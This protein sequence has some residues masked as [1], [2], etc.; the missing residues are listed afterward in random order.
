M[1]IYNASMKIKQRLFQLS[2]P[3]GKSVFLWG[4]RK[5]GKSYWVR[6]HQPNAI[7]I[8]L[9]KT[10][11]FADYA[12]RPPLL[13]ERYSEATSLVVIDEVQ[14]LPVILNEVHWLISLV[15]CLLT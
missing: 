12:S 4:P 6:E 14:N 15:Y 3:E 11:V 1:I 7:L 2:L 13:R 9:L 5:V 10:D 8:D